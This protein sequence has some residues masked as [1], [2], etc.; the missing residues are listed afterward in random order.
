MATPKDNRIEAYVLLQCQKAGGGSLF[1]YDRRGLSGWLVARLAAGLAARLV[2][3]NPIGDALRGN[4]ELGDMR[5]EGS[6]EN[7]QPF[8]QLDPGEAPRFGFGGKGLR[9]AGASLFRQNTAL[10]NFKC[11]V[12]V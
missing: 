11:H 4:D 6:G 8:A 9:L 5:I 2:L 12:P 3:G 1:R 7:I 10:M